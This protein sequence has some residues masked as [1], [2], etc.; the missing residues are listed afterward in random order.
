MALEYRNH[1]DDPGAWATELGISREA[2]EIYLSGDVVDL[3]VDSFIWHR[4]LGYDLTKRHGNGPLDAS[5]YSQVDFPRIREGAVTGA[6]WVIT[7]NPLR[8]SEGRGEAF[9]RNIAE[10]QRVLA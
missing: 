6:I 10:L 2:V 8:G 3:H 5:F 1:R 9:S 7:T 4:I